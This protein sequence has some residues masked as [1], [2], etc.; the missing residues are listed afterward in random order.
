MS[1]RTDFGPRSDGTRQA[2]SASD[3]VRFDSF[4]HWMGPIKKEALVDAGFAYK[5]EEDEVQCFCCKLVIRNWTKDMDPRAE[6]VKRAPG[7]E[8]L[9][10]LM[11]SKDLAKMKEKIFDV[12]KMRAE[13][14]GIFT[15]P[16]NN[17]T[18]ER[19]D[20]KVH[21]CIYIRTSQQSVEQHTD[22]DPDN[23]TS[24][25]EAIRSVDM[26]SNGSGVGEN[27]VQMG[28]SGGGRRAD[29][30]EP[31]PDTGMPVEHVPPRGELYQDAGTHGENGGDNMDYMMQSTAAQSI[32]QRGY[33]TEDDVRN[34]IIDLRRNGKE[35]F[36]GED[37]M[38]LIVG[39]GSYSN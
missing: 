11:P 7:C 26:F 30:R 28:A 25:R 21:D 12:T 39:T 1:R 9:T 37:I 6:H 8:Y 29:E 2:P 19:V 14:E 5:G 38:M 17:I 18:G 27:R 13:T 33:G 20:E 34:A 23:G 10:Q 15:W 31:H 35:D 36:N 4:L 3:N 24:D 22:N 16:C 32:L